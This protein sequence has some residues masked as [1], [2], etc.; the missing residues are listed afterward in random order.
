MGDLR[1]GDRH[2]ATELCSRDVPGRADIGCNES[3]FAAVCNSHGCCTGRG[4]LRALVVQKRKLYDDGLEL[5]PRGV[6]EYA[7]YPAATR[8]FLHESGFGHWQVVNDL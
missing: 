7:R 2:D 3:P 5:V 8:V 4:D 6:R 1:L